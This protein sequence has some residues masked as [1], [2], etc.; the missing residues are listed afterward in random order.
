MFCFLNRESIVI[1]HVE[2]SP[3]T[4]VLQ[5]NGT[6]CKGTEVFL[7]KINFNNFWKTIICVLNNKKGLPPKYVP[8]VNDDD[9]YFNRNSKINKSFHSSNHYDN[10]NNNNNNNNIIVNNV[11]K[12]D[13]NT[14]NLN[15]NKEYWN[16][17]NVIIKENLN[18]NQKPSGHR[19]IRS[20][21]YIKLDDLIND[22]S[23]QPTS[24]KLFTVLIYFLFSSFII[25]RYKSSS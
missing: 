15:R 20:H 6:N 11:N 4:T 12:P 25:C 3:L 10:R 14:G 16:Y 8:L 21:G 19:R 23:P 13:K 1:R 17:N 22:N 18:T 5:K 24:K 2:T 7:I 9:I